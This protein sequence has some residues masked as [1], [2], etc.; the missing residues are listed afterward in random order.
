MENN[1]E[2]S[3]SVESK[4][5]SFIRVTIFII[6]LAVI[7]FLIAGT[8]NWPMAWVYLVTY[9]L[10]IT[11]AS[12][13][14]PV[15]KELVE[16]RTGIKEDAKNWDKVLASFLS[17]MIPVG[18]LLI[19]AVNKR[20][21]TP[22]QMDRL[23]QIIALFIELAGYGLAIWAGAV[24]RFYSRYVRIQKERNH[25]VVKSGPYQFI[26]HPGY[27]GIMLFG[28]ATG[29]VLDSIWTVAAGVLVLILTIIRTA[30][31]DRVLQKELPGYAEYA[32]K[33]RYRLVPGVW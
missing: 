31:E 9:Y 21:G 7:F 32:Q 19:A 29:L 33:T 8:I 28:I 12:L 16:E 25:T 3:K 17:F 5:K 6:V 10:L 20:F 14:V 27:S 24:N 2:V 15:E 13:V 4:G 11:M 30:L 22:L 23:T 1:P 18:L 26:R